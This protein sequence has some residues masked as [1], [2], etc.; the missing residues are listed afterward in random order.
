MS[1]LLGTGPGIKV[2][3]KTD[4]QS[5]IQHKVNI[6]FELARTQ[7]QA[8]CQL[9]ELLLVDCSIHTIGPATE[10]TLSP[11]FVLVRGTV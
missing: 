11:N 2:C 4:N 10:K 9:H 8:G 7:I 6:C 1:S 3:K 5:L